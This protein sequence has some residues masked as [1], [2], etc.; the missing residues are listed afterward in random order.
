MDLAECFRKVQVY[1]RN[2]ISLFCMTCSG[3]FSR[4]AK[5]GFH[6]WSYVC[7]FPKCYICLYIKK[8]F[9]YSVSVC[10]GE[11][12][13]LLVPSFLDFPRNHISTSSTRGILIKRLHIITESQKPFIL[14]SNRT[15]ALNPLLQ[16]FVGF[17]FICFYN[18][19]AHNS[20]SEQFWDSLKPGPGLGSW[21]VC[22][23]SVWCPSQTDQP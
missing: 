20:I 23:C 19:F 16:W 12:L 4:A 5:L 7:F 15:P 21:A 6:L 3:N 11:S 13:G 9:L 2:L 22:S 10:L 18:I 1:C 17:A 14:S 8:W